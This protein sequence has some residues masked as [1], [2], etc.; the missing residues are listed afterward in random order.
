MS[1]RVNPVRTRFG[2]ASLL[3][4]DTQDSATSSIPQEARMVRLARDDEGRGAA[5]RSALPA[6][7]LALHLLVV[8]LEHLGDLLLRHAFFDP[9]VAL[10]TQHRFGYLR[11]QLPHQREKLGVERLGHLVEPLPMDI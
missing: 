10:M 4:G 2:I 11:R 6:P 7:A 8:E 5:R 3:D 9:P 1:V